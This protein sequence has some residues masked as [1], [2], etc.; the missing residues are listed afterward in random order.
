M[1]EDLVIV[2]NEEEEAAARRV[3]WNDVRR[4]G[5]GRETRQRWEAEQILVAEMG[6][7]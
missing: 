2:A 6:C 4:R 3:A 1:A 7:S 5:M